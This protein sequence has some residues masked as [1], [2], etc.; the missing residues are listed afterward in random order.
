M[1]VFLCRLISLS[2]KSFYNLQIQYT[3]EILDYTPTPDPEEPYFEIDA[4]TGNLIALKQLVYAVEP[5]R[6]V[7][8]VTATEQVS[9][10][11]TTQQVCGNAFVAASIT[12]IALL[13]SF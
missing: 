1:Y 11:T 12:I 10:F 5:H 13:S 6:Y 2:A 8:N 7:V 3:L 4:T 9:G